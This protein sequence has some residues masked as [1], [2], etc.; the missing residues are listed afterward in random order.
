MKIRWI[1]QSGYVI[2]TEHTTI[3]IDPYLSDV[4]E[5][6]HGR[7]RLIEAPISPAELRA[8]AVIC[9]HDHADHLDIGAVPEMD[10]GLFFITTAEGVRTLAGLGKHNAKALAV[11]ES[12]TV[13]DVTVTAVF[14]DHTVEA[15]GVIL[16]GEGRTLWFSG[17]TYYHERLFE[18]A[19]YAPD[20]AFICINGRLGNMNVEE[21]VLTAKRMG[22]KIS[23][24]NHYGMFASNTEDPEKF[25]S[26][27]PGSIA[28]RPDRINDIEALL[29]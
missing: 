7:P 8:D 9:T 6:S 26:R 22:A 16:Q 20:I 24:P 17:D 12:I 15:M 2:T 11:G 28:L 5:I 14:A 19:A 21:A 23:I 18:A 1:G 10:D 13:G 29:G 25:T 4:V 3:V 27:V